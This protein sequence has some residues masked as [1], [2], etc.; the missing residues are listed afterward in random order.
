MTGMN[1]RH[2]AQGLTS[3]SSEIA[4]M[5]PTAQTLFTGMPKMEVSLQT[6]LQRSNTPLD[7]KLQIVQRSVCSPEA[8]SFAAS[9]QVS[10]WRSLPGPAVDAEVPMVCQLD[11]IAELH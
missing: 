10:G 4:C 1:S 2:S 8:V 7:L 5:R 9:G 11:Q 6:L 3:G